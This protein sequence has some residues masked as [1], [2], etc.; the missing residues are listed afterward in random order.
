MY[1]RHEDPWGFDSRWYEERK[2][3]VLLAALPRRTY[4]STLEAGCSTGA[5]TA[6]LADRS[7]RVLAVDLAPAALDRARA[8]LAGRENVEFRLATLPAAWP[9]GF[10]SWWCCRRW[11]TTGRG[12]DLD[13]G[14]T[15]AVASLSTGGHLVACH[16]RH[17]VAEYPRTGDEVHDALAARPD[18]VRL[19][20]HEEQDFVLEVYAHPGAL[21]VAAESGLVP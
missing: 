3:A 8:R 21:S 13:R 6:Q 18:L 15:A 7:D 14:L 19:A 16:W 17:P 9:E 10:S 4:R 20:R 2:R 12:A 1:A 11:R 5:L